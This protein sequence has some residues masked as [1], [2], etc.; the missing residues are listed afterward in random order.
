VLLR[1]MRRRKPGAPSLLA[2]VVA[3][4]VVIGMLGLA[5]PT[6]AAPVSAALRWLLALL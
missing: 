2:R 1:M 5:A 4:L 3:A 6:L